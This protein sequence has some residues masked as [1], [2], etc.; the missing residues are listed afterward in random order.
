MVPLLRILAIIITMAGAALAHDD[1]AWIM[2]KYPICCGPQ[3]CAVVPR[4][5]VYMTAKGW[6]VQGLEGTVPK[7]QVKQSEDLQT[8]ACRIIDFSDYDYDD[9]DLI[10]DRVRCLFL[11]PALF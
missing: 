4:S 9:E 11:P 1:A 7:D 8:W 2:E 6:V 3:D 5:A 10:P